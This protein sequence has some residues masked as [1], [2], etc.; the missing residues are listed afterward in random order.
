MTV[1][2]VWIKCSLCCDADIC[3]K[4]GN[5]LNRDVLCPH[6]IFCEQ[7]DTVDAE[8][9]VPLPENPELSSFLKP[10]ADGI[11]FYK[12][13]IPLGFLLWEV[14]VAFLRESQL[15]WQIHATQPVV[16]AWCFLV[17]VIHQSWTWTTGFS[18]C[19]CDLFTCAYTGS[20]FMV[21]FKGLLWGRESAENLILGKHKV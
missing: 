19:I 1:D 20:W 8:I 5:K 4:S 2:C 14:W 10:L 7:W 9:K 11:F 16:S 18:T 21:S 17:F 13:I 12:C 15:L 3:V 6:G